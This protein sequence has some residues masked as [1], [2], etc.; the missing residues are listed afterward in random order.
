MDSVSK[1]AYK[2]I[3]PSLVHAFV[4]AFKDGTQRTASSTLSTRAQNA[5]SVG[6]DIQVFFEAVENPCD[7]DDNPSGYFVLL[8]AENKLMWKETA[9]KIEQAEQQQ[10][11]PEWIFACGNVGGSLRFKSSLAKMMQ[12]WIKPKVDPKY[13]RQNIESLGF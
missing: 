9:S 6:D 7:P 5:F 11:L 13:L 3:V 1:C 4:G 10:S 2:N 12:R 8:V